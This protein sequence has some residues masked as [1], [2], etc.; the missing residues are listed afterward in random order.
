[1]RGSRQH[2]SFEFALDAAAGK[3]RCSA[4]LHV[5]LDGSG[6]VE[7]IAATLHDV[8]DRVG[9]EQFANLR[10]ELLDRED[11]LDAVLTDIVGER[12]VLRERARTW[13]LAGLTAREQ[14]ILRLMATGKT[15]RQIG[16][17]LGMSA[18]TVR[19]RISMLLPKLGA[20]DRTQAVAIA[21]ESGLLGTFNVELE[22]AQI[23]DFAV[24]PFNLGEFE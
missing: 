8:S 3:L 24:R 23:E 15:N 1:V 21:I 17:E 20:A 10:R 11:R 9:Q 5:V 13:G 7:F 19:N 16:A 2:Q 4:N 6:S 12:A 14:T 18:G 22:P